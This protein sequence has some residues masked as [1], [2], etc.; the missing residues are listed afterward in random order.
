MGFYIERDY[1]ADLDGNRGYDLVDFDITEEDKEEILEELYPLFLEGEDGSTGEIE[2]YLYCP[3]TEENVGVMI[4]I[5][6]Y[7]EDLLQMASEDEDIKE[8]EDIQ[9]Y[10]QEVKENLNKQLRGDN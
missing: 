7:I 1:S 4:D 3:F 10:L 5:N 9:E 6:D 8:D 2:I